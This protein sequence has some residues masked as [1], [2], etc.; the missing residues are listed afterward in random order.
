MV[1]RQSLLSV[2]SFSRYTDKQVCT[3]TG[4]YGQLTDWEDEAPPPHI[5][6]ES[7]R[8]SNHDDGHDKPHGCKSPENYTDHHTDNVE[9]L[10]RK[11]VFDVRDGMNCRK[12]TFCD[13]PKCY[14][15]DTQSDSFDFDNI[16]QMKGH[17]REA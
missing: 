4:T 3:W 7:S 14:Q 9:D 17:S 2:I 12:K 5:E 13:F 15:P 8:Q 6:R 1:S 16:F 11:G 10:A